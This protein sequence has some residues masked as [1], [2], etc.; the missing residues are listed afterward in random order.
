MKKTATVR[1]NPPP[2]PPL[3]S[4]FPP[5]KNGG[6]RGDFPAILL[7]TLLWTPPSVFAEDEP[8]ADEPEAAAPV[9]VDLFGSKP[10]EYSK[11]GWNHYGPGY[12]E[13]DQETGVLS[14]HGGM[15]LL[16]YGARELQDFVL[17]LE[18]KCAGERTNSGVFLRVPEMPVSDEYIYHSFEVQ[19]DDASEGTHHTGAVFDA[20]APSEHAGKPAGEWNQMRITFVGDRIRV[21]INGKQVVDW[22]AEPRGKIRDFAARGFIGLQNH[23]DVAPVSFRNV[24]LAELP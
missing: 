11:H 4:A 7:L 12:F 13:L 3:G 18:Y 8:G 1:P 23:D 9:F 17:E 19:I 21:E 24:R 2:T 6:S 14:S 20:E 16:W 5:L 15:G 10:G 22:Q